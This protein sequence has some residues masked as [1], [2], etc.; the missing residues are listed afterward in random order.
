M[1][2]IHKGA[3]ATSSRDNCEPA[4]VVWLRRAIARENEVRAA[5]AKARDER[6]QLFIGHGDDVVL[7]IEDAVT[8]SI[9]IL[10]VMRRR[11]IFDAAAAKRLGQAMAFMFE[12]RPPQGGQIHGIFDGH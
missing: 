5:A 7:G 2:W 12:R 8:V 10:G 4:V 11:D 9:G 1:T 3:P 6:K